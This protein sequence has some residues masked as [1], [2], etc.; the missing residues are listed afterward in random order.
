MKLM[1]NCLCAGNTLQRG[2]TRRGNA[3][4]H[5]QTCSS[6]SKDRGKSFH[7]F[8]GPVKLMEAYLCAERTLQRRFNRRRGAVKHVQAGLCPIT[9]REMLFSPL[10]R[11]YE[12]RASLLTCGKHLTTPF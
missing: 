12:A 8:G 1:Q 2:F 11:S 3:V 4:K 5:V 7:H 9:D 6:G 10:W